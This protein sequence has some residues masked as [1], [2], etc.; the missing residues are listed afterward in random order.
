MGDCIAVLSLHACPAVG[1]GS[2]VTFKGWD[3]HIRTA[4]DTAVFNLQVHTCPHRYQ[5]VVAAPCPHRQSTDSRVGRGAD[6]CPNLKPLAPG[7]QRK[8]LTMRVLDFAT[9]KKTCNGV[10]GL[11]DCGTKRSLALFT[12]PPTTIYLLM[13]LLLI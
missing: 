1:G 12:L 11:I 8:S 2:E 9:L 6:V 4:P 7:K 3:T 13:Y 10:E 5:T